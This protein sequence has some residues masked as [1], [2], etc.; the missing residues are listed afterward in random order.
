MST[1]IC[2]SIK[3]PM[4]KILK[5]NKFDDFIK[6][7]S[8]YHYKTQLI[9]AN[10]YDFIK[11]YF[12]Y[13]Y[14]NN[15]NFDK[16][17][18]NFFVTVCEVTTTHSKKGRPNGNVELIGK[19][20][21]YYTN[22]YSKTNPTC[23][24]SEHLSSILNYESDDYITHLETN[25]KEHY[26]Q[27]AKK[28]VKIYFNY[29]DKL[30]QILKINSNKV[31]KE[32]LKNFNYEFSQI[33]CDMFSINRKNKLISPKSNHVWLM[34]LRKL[35]VP[36]KSTYKKDNILYDL[37]YDPQFY[38]RS[39]FAING[40]LEKISTKENELRLFNVLPLKTGYIPSHIT[41][42]T[43]TLILLFCKENSAYNLQNISKVKNDIWSNFFKFDTRKFKKKKYGF[44]YFIKTDGVSCSLIFAKINENGNFCKE[45]KNKVKI[46]EPYIEEQYNVQNIL[47]KYKVG[48]GDPNYGNLIQM[49]NEK[50][51]IYRYTRNQRN[52]ES[53][54]KKY[55]NIR[56]NELNTKVVGGKTIKE[57]QN[58]LSGYN[59]KTINCNKFFSY[60]KGKYEGQMIL[61]KHYRQRIF[62]K[63]KLNVYTNIQ[64]SE[65]KMVKNINKKIGNPKDT[66]LIWGGL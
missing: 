59:S 30:K 25:I 5:E 52:Q 49:E 62:R 29:D 63:F 66:I 13:L 17:N 23:V 20:K 39:M 44:K 56:E 31:R 11:L 9:V 22:Y 10:A 21:Q 50:G 41:I 47:K 14:E 32:K 61:Y 64:K 2:K 60:L 46:E 1:E 8:K 57:R 18:R 27:H 34:K 51:D 55:T 53:G 4:C 65:S 35:I 24:E 40:E 58:K 36:I 33:I 48:V 12:C 28:L 3:L 6:I 42:D 19:L 54:T 38:L 45:S 37:E 26:F 15:L 43:A 16:I 7:F